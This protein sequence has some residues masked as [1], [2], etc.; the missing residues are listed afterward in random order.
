MTHTPLSLRFDPD[1]H[2]P[3]DAPASVDARNTAVRACQEAYAFVAATEQTLERLRRTAF[4]SPEHGQIATLR[5]ALGRLTRGAWPAELISAR[6]DLQSA[7]DRAAGIAS[8]A[9]LALEGAARGGL[10]DTRGD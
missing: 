8:Q 2:S 7:R 6:T 4:G 9:G 3:L 5:D 1:T 10:I